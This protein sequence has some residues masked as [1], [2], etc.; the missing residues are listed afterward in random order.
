MTQPQQDP[1]IKA[2]PIMTSEDTSVGETVQSGNNLVEVKISQLPRFYVHFRRAES[3]SLSANNLYYKGEYGFDWLRDEYIYDEEKVA[4][5]NKPASIAQGENADFLI[6]QYTHHDGVFIE[7]INEI[8]TNSTEK[9][10][11]AWASL[12]QNQS[13]KLLLQIDV[14]ETETKL[15]NATGI[16]L[17]FET[18]AGI[19]VTPN[20]VKLADVIQNPRERKNKTLISN[21][22][23][24]KTKTF[25]RISTNFKVTILVSTKFDKP[26]F[27]KVKAVS[28]SKL[29]NYVGL[30]ILYP[31]AQIKTANL[32]VIYFYSQSQTSTPLL[33]KDYEIFIRENFFNQAIIK[34]NFLSEITIDVHQEKAKRQTSESQNL[35]SSIFRG[36]KA[37]KEL[38]KFIAKYPKAEYIKSDSN[39]TL[40]S[41]VQNLIKL[42]QNDKKMPL[43]NKTSDTPITY[44]IVTDFVVTDRIGQILGGYAICDNTCRTNS[45]A[46][47]CNLFGN[48]LFITTV[49]KQSADVTIYCLMHELGH[50]FGL[51]HTFA[52]SNEKIDFCKNYKTA[53][54]MDYENICK[55]Y[56]SQYIPNDMLNK[57]YQGYTDNI[58]DYGFGYKED[59]NMTSGISQINNKSNGKM[60]SL[61]KWQWDI[62]RKD[63]NVQ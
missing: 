25:E 7:E 9:Y 5:L 38:E 46:G 56:F 20:Q 8:K 26:I 29:V 62:M 43:D 54:N 48:T 11:P 49:P 52:G 55:L 47:Q 17:I 19:Q 27:I 21:K 51:P 1:N 12:M 15:L 33:P 32:Q 53:Q 13:A 24:L 37:L 39:D 60:W 40:D 10:I 18:S 6:K 34:P 3:N 2:P 58:M 4:M 28:G 41:D 63:I 50:S 61:Y 22:K 14:D 23:D 42:L 30:L 16:D 31:N 45:T 57:F 44:I 36:D 59:K 35:I